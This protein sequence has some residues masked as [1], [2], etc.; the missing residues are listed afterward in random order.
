MQ[1]RAV[2]RV[3]RRDAITTIIM[4]RPDRRNAVDPMAVELRRAFREFEEDDSQKVAI[5]AASTA[6][7][8][9]API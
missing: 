3:E 9:P 2:V 1:G 5:F 7:S 6:S 4:D 8:A